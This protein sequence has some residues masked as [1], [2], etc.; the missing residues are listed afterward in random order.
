MITK[1]IPH[2]SLNN[3]NGNRKELI[4]EKLPQPSQQ[5]IE[6]YIECYNKDE[7]ITDVLVEYNSSNDSLDYGGVYIPSSLKINPK[8]NT[9][10]IKK[11]K[12]SWTREEVVILLNKL[13]HTLNIGS[14]LTLE[15][16][17]EENL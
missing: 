1:S 11:L 4:V 15:Q 16:W 9:I 7:I 13:N 12:E 5:F 8:D 17:I 2:S 6:K 3:V 10:T 14:D